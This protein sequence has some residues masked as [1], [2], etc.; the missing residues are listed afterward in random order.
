[1][2]DIADYKGFYLQKGTGIVKESNAEWGIVVK[3]FDWSC[4]MLKPKEYAST[5]FKDQNGKYTFVPQVLKFESGKMKLTFLYIGAYNTFYQNLVAFQ[6]YLAN[7]GEFKFQDQ[8]SGIG[9]QNVRWTDSEAPDVISKNK[10]DGDIFTFGMT[11]EFDDP[12]TDI[13]LV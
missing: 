8:F 9:R 13:I 11:F 2:I 6:T 5:D 4:M 1:M 10:A 12:I 3:K 7:G